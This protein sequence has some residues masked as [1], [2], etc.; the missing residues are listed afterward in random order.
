MGSM[1]R[2]GEG[3]ETIEESGC[4]WTYVALLIPSGRSMQQIEVHEEHVLYWFLRLYLGGPIL[5]AGVGKALD[6]PAFIGVMKTYGLGLPEWIMSPMSLAVICLETGLGL[7]MVCGWRLHD[8]ALLSIVLH[9][10][11]LVLLAS[12]LWRGLNLQNSCCFGMFLPQPLKWHSLLE[13]VVPLAFSC[14]LLRLT[15]TR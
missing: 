8:A 10:G 12:A 13:H 14:A 6:I 9:A 2:A 15:R 1:A 5:V 11:Y 4:A 3:F 7:W